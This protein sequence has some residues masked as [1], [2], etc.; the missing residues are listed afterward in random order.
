MME[1]FEVDKILAHQIALIFCF[2]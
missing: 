1:K 2:S